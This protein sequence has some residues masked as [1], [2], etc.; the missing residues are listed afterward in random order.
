MKIIRGVLGFYQIAT[1]IIALV[2]LL[3][4]FRA[5]GVGFAATLALFCALS[6][7]AGTA[8]FLTERV[9][10]RLTQ[11][12]QLVQ[13]IGIFSPLVTFVISEGPSARVVAG[14]VTGSVTNNIVFTATWRFG[15]DFGLA[16]LRT[17]E[18]FPLVG[19]SVNFVA[20]ALV[21][22]TTRLLRKPTPE[23]SVSAQPETGLE[24][25][26]STGSG[27]PAKSRKNGDR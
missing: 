16:Y 19:F 12:N 13:G 1:A 14:V 20:L 9:G 15:P 27:L 17:L 23:S 24:L 5:Y 25:N 21:A 22:V 26:Q 11:A 10:L 6:I 7:A 18:G 4:A 8:V 3:P 2:S